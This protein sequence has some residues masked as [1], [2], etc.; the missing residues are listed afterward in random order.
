M[1]RAARGPAGGPW[2]PW[3]HP[4]TDGGGGGEEQVHSGHSPFSPF[5][6]TWTHPLRHTRQVPAPLQAPP[7]PLP[8][9][10]PPC[11]RSRCWIGPCF[12]KSCIWWPC[13]SRSASRSPSS[14]ALA[15]RPGLST[16]TVCCLGPRRPGPPQWQLTFSFSWPLCC[17]KG[18]PPEE[19]QG[20]GGG[21]GP[22]PRQ[23]TPSPQRERNGTWYVR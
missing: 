12:R 11:R 8:P 16:V 15:G 4:W 5:P 1:G 3:R 2:A 21:A 20:E 18:I 13:A 19:T 23:Q 17:L 10:P 6:R 22:R 14:S 9:L 7:L